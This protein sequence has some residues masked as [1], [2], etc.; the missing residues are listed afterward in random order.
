MENRTSQWALPLMDRSIAI[1][2]FVVPN[3]RETGLILWGDIGDDKT[4]TYELMVAGGDGQNRPQVDAA[5]DFIGRLLVRPLQSVKLLKKAH[6]GV[7]AR[8]GERDPEAVGY[9]IAPI[10]SAQGY[11]LMTPAYTDSAKRRIT[12]IPSGVQNTIGGELRLPIG[13]VDLRGEAY[14]VSNHTREAVNGYEL[15][16]TERLGTMNGFAFTGIVDW[17]ALGDEYI[18]GDPG[19]RRPSKLNLKK[20][21]EI[22]RGLQLTG[23]VSGITGAYDGNARGGSDD[24]ATPGSAGNPASDFSVYQFSLGASYWHSKWVRMMGQY[25]LYYTPGSGSD[26]NLAVVPGNVIEGADAD[27]HL[28]HEIGA[29][30]QLWF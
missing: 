22:Q 17:W 1:R 27:S 18:S 15:T 9:P 8:H 10:T 4:F 26:D 2:S 23:L 12:V 13:P 3:A 16:N 24:A 6:V 19:Y 25:A 21:V 29:R 14:Y 20:K 28:L 11:T 30:L 7:S 5:A